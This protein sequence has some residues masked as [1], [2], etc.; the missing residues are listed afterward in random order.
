MGV[1]AMGSTDRIHD[2]PTEVAGQHLSRSS[3]GA[4]PARDQLG[5]EPVSGSSDVVQFDEI[6][7]GKL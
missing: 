3:K 7:C 2:G 6:A 1:A 5:R 4:I